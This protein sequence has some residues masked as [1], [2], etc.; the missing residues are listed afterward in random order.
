MER[1]GLGTRKDPHTYAL[2]GM[3]QV[4][5]DRFIE[6]FMRDNGAEAATPPDTDKTRPSAA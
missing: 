5:T 2:P 4:G 1:H 6:R 3:A